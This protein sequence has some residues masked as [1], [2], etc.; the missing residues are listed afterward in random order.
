VKH[1][2]LNQAA[3]RAGWDRTGEQLVDAWKQEART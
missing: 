2:E 3:L 1:I